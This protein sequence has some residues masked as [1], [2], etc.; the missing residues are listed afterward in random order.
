[1]GVRPVER[2]DGDRRAAIAPLVGERRAAIAAEAAL[3]AAR[4]LEI[5]RLAAGPLQR[6]S[7]A[8]ERGHQVPE[9]LLA[10]AAVA[11]RGVPHRALGAVA[12]GA[13]LAAAG[14]AL[15][16]MNSLPAKRS[17]AMIR[18]CRMP[19]CEKACPAPSTRTNSASGQARCRSQA[20]AAGQAMSYRP[21]TMTAGM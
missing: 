8:D 19:G 3:H 16:H 12:H 1:H 15:A 17:V 14:E 11:D 6:G 10:H 18:W 9:R 2:A 21:C 7:E 5:A 4:A 13:A 20:V